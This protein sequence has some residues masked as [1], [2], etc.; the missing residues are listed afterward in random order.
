ME[1]S[2]AK[3]RANCKATTG[4]DEVDNVHSQTLFKCAP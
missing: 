2:L 4:V 1:L 3:N